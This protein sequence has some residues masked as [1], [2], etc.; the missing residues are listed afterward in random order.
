MELFEPIPAD[1]ADIAAIDARLEQ[2][3]QKLSEYEASQARMAQA[4]SDLTTDSMNLKDGNLD[5]IVE[6]V[7]RMIDIVDVLADC[8]AANEELGRAL[9]EDQRQNERDFARLI[10]KADDCFRLPGNES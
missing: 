2:Q 5:G 6:T 1:E 9:M 3:R 10:Q 7:Q 8:S 4:M